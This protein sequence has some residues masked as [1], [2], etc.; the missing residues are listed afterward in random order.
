MEKKE[1][2]NGEIAIVWK[3]AKCTHSGVCVH[4]LP[5]VYK[6]TKKPWISPENA[7]TSELIEQVE[8][9]PSGALTYY[10]INK[11]EEK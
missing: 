2:K 7:T 10:R 8:K 4:A 3:P 5:N 9:C 1:Y 6:P 11:I